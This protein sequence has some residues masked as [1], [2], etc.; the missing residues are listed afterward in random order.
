MG[1]EMCIRDR[2]FQKDALNGDG[3]L[4]FNVAVPAPED[5]GDGWYEWNIDNWGTKWG[6]CYPEDP[7]VS[8]DGAEFSVSFETA[9]APPTPWVHAIASKH[10]EVTVTLAYSEPGMEFEGIVEVKGDSV[11]TDKEF[12]TVEDKPSLI[13]RLSERGA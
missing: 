12:E 11:L 2:K 3:E 6:P 4:D 5:I 9:W 13:D 10:P 1:A 7:E 8:S